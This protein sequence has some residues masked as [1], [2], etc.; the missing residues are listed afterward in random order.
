MAARLGYRS[1]VS[2]VL[3]IRSGHPSSVV[4]SRDLS[5]NGSA[6]AIPLPTMTT[7]QAVSKP[8]NL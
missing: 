3:V 4:V 7:V 2:S 8:K 5:A 6:A 1:N